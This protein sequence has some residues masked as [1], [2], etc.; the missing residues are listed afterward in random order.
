MI[1]K[2]ALGAAVALQPFSL[3]MVL[4]GVAWGIVG[5][6][7]PGITGSIAM[8]LLLRREVVLEAGGYHA[9]YFILF[10]DHDLSYRLRSSGHRIRLV[11]AALVYHR[12]GTAG[13]SYREGSAYPGRRALL[14]SR[15][16][17]MLLLRNHSLAALILGSP[18]VL[19]YE[20][21]WVAFA[22]LKGNLGDYLRENG[23]D[24]GQQ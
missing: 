16:R 1:E 12:E 2:L 5:G 4:L 11:P 3:L 6:A 14:H 9:D 13:I 7:L 23:V 24:K 8:A 15:N 17:W 10:E 20:A 19:L 18:G 22:T 21:A